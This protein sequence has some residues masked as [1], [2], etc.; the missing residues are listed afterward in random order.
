[1]RE[2]GYAIGIFSPDELRNASQQDVETTLMREGNE[3]IDVLSP[4]DPEDF[5]DEID[6][7]GTRVGL[8][9]LNRRSRALKFATQ[10]LTIYR[11]N[12]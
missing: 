12:L 9:I 3:A 10:L 4:P 1:M 8:D 5:E 6:D 11:E 2:A 7:K